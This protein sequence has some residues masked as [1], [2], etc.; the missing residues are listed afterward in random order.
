L[1]PCGAT[2]A[3]QWLSHK[4][5]LVTEVRPLSQ[6]FLLSLGSSYSIAHLMSSIAL[7]I[8]HT[9]EST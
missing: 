4:I 8:S 9:A 6:L 1:S 5:N 2:P 7:S 3:H